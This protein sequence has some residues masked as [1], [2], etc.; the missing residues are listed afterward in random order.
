MAEAT[1]VL[2]GEV[3]N[4]V[5]MLLVSFFVFN[6]HY[7]PGLSNFYTVLEVLLLRQ[8]PKECPI[9]I[10]N[11]LSQLNYTGF[12]FSVWHCIKVPVQYFYCIA[13]CM[14]AVMY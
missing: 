12:S 13:N 10:S 1:S 6:I 11:V 2:Q 9:I 4:T 3:T 5:T 14:L 8:V 7:P